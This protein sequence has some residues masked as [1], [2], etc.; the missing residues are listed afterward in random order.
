MKRTKAESEQTRA[1]II[2]KA[3]Q[4]FLR[5]GFSNCTLEEIAKSAN[6]TRGAIYWHFED[7]LD[8]IK[9]LV[10]FQHRRVTELLTRPIYVDISA[11]AKI[12]SIVVNVIT[13]FFED[14]AFRDFVELTWFKIEYTHSKRL[15]ST[16]AE[17][18]QLFMDMLMRLVREGRKDQSIKPEVRPFD[19]AF[20][21]TTMINGLYRMYFTLPPEAIQKQQ[22]I[23][24]FESYLRLI[25]DKERVQ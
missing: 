15:I 16:K 7:K 11:I 3:M 6:V 2:N 18:N 19:A 23:K 13:H 24:S 9:E 22:A 14:K 25:E 17:S 4:L 12:R 21:V 20:T 5:R 1:L 10:E 8:I